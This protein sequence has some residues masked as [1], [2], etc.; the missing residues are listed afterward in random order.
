MENHR[1]PS[2]YVD[3]D[4]QDQLIVPRY[5]ISLPLDHLCAS[6]TRT[7]NGRYMVNDT[8]YKPGKLVIFYEFGKGGVSDWDAAVLLGGWNGMQS[9]ALALV[10]IRNGLVM[11][12]DHRF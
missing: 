2:N 3:N 8:Y 7:F 11:G 1:W 12:W 5:N 4:E 9:A 10:K 6:D